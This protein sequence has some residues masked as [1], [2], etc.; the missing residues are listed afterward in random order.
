MSYT[1]YHS[2]KT[3]AHGIMFDSKREAQRFEELLLMERAGKISNLQRQ[4]KY[5]LIPS[6]WDTV[7]GKRRCVERACNYVADFVYQ[8]NGRTVVEDTKG[9][10]TPEYVI[11][12]KLMLFRLHIKVREVK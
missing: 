8:Q 11:K 7:N 6:Q 1:K 3:N 5:E 4:V 9:M 2:R 12:R 10:K